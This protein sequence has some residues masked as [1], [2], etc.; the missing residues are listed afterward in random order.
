V[1]FD[2]AD[3]EIL[4]KLY[5]N[6]MLRFDLVTGLL[7]SREPAT[8]ERIANAMEEMDDWCLSEK[9]L[10]YERLKSTDKQAL[11]ASI[12]FLDILDGLRRVSDHLSTIALAFDSGSK[13][14][15]KPRAKTSPKA[16]TGGAELRTPS[17]SKQSST[18]ETLGAPVERI[19]PN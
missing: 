19:K 6:T 10:H 1:S 4:I 8:A 5:Q 15:R 14:A 3:M 12:C 17:A 16:P 13:R 18:P 11:A 2:S 9:K 7:T